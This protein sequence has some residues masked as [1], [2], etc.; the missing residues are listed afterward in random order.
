[1]DIDLSGSNMHGGGGGGNNFNNGGGNSWPS[2]P[3]V[4]PEPPNT[5]ALTDQIASLQSNQM[6]LQDQIKTS[7][8]N[9]AAQWTVLQQNNEIMTRDQIMK[10]Q[11]ADLEDLSR[12][13]N[14]SLSI[15]DSVLQPII[16][17]CTKDAIS[18]GKSWIFQN[19][20]SLDCNRQVSGFL[21]VPESRF[22]ERRL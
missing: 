16:E 11:E 21:P 7:E 4:A 6:T 12:S 22:W 20:N 10:A 14:V 3:A 17:S 5:S 19:S 15:F 1:M 2:S 18:S 8:Q 9:L 13:T